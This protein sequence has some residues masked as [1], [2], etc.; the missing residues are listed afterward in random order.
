MIRIRWTLSAAHDLQ[1]INDYLR[2]HHPSYRQPTLRK[3]YESIRSLKDSPNRGRPGSEPGT[4]ELVFTPL[5]YIAIYRV[6]KDAIEVLRVY[7]GA[8][9]R[10]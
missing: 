1:D 6:S 2:R 9:H 5:P 3:L 7:H 4:R 10:R 8:Q